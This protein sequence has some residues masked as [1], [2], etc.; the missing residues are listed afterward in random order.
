MFPKAVLHKR[1]GHRHPPAKASLS[2]GE[3]LRLVHSDR[4]PSSRPSHDLLKFAQIVGTER[5]IDLAAATLHQVDGVH[6]PLPDALAR[7]QADLAKGDLADVRLALDALVAHA[8]LAAR[9]VS[10][11][12]ASARLR[13]SRR[14]LGA[15]RALVNV[16]GVVAEALRALPPQA[17]EVRIEPRLDATLPW[18]VGNARQLQ[19]VLLTLLA[20]ATQ[21]VTATGRGGTIAVETAHAAGAL[22]GERIVRLLVTHDGHA[23]PGEVLPRLFQPFSSVAAADRA[24]DIDLGFAGRLIA[25][26]GGAVWAE[27]LPAGGVRIMAEFPAV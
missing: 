16:N 3:I 12:A 7:T 11:L 19:H 4:E 2:P 8:E 23:V 25:E 9:M 13:G 14:A 27:N 18:I 20:Y 24:P 15:E 10:E 17:A 26:H 1:N 5:S 6:S 22:H 21:A